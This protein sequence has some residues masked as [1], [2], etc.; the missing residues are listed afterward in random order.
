MKDLL[1]EI[2]LGVAETFI[3]FA[4]KIMPEGKEKG[5][6]TVFMRDYGSRRIKEMTTYFSKKNK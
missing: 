6:L 4:F 1:R 3:D 5:E 2:R